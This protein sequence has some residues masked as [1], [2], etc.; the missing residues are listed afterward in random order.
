MNKLITSAIVLLLSLTA[1]A[2]VPVATYEMKTDNFKQ[3]DETTMSFELWFRKTSGED[4]GLFTWQL[5]WQFNT[6]ALNGGAFQ[7]ANFTIAPGADGGIFMGHYNNADAVVAPNGTFFSY[8]P[9]SFPNVGENMTVITADWKHIA[10]F[11]AQATKNGNPHNFAAAHLELA[12][13]IGGIVEVFASQNPYIFRTEGQITGTLTT[14]P[15]APISDREM[16]SHWFTG[17]GNWTDAA[18]WNNVTTENANTVPGA[19][20]N[21]GIGGSATI[22]DAKTAGEVTVAQGG[23]LLVNEAG[24]LTADLVFN[25]NS[26]APATDVTV[27]LWD[28]EAGEGGNLPYTA[29]Q[30]NTVNDGI[31]SFTTTANVT[32]ILDAGDL[33]ITGGTLGPFADVWRGGLPAT[34][35]AWVAQFSSVGIENLKLSSVQW[36]DLNDDLGS[37]VGPNSFS[38]QY[39]F[40]NSSWTTITTITVSNDLTTGVLADQALPSALDNQAVVY[41]RWRT[42]ATDNT[43]NGFSFIDNVVIVGDEMPAGITLQSSASGT[44][45]LIH[46]NTGVAATVQR[47]LPGAAAAWHGISAPVSGMDILASEWYPGA[48]EDLYLWS[49]AAPGWWVNVKN[50][51]GSGGTPDFPTANGGNDFAMGRGYIVNYNSA[52][53]TKSFAG[54]LNAGELQVPLLYNSSKLWE[55]E[56]GWNL[57]GNPY[58]SGLNFNTINK[59]NLAEDYAQ[60]YDPNKDGG[61]GYVTATT[62]AAGQAFFV[63]AANS[64]AFLGLQ[65]T[66]QLHGGTFY[67]NQTAANDKLLL[68]LSNDTYYDETQLLLKAGSQAGYDYYDASKIYSLNNEIPQ[69]SS[70]VDQRPLLINSI[71]QLSPSTIV[72]LRLLIPANG[73]Y[74]LEA[75]TIEGAFEQE[76]LFV[77][78]LETGLIHDLKESAYTFTAKGGDTDRLQIQFEVVGLSETENVNAK[79]WYANNHIHINGVTGTYTVQLT[80]LSGRFLFSREAELKLTDQFAVL[81]E[82]GVY[83]LVLNG[84]KQTQTLKV[85]VD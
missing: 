11:T 41:L 46:N 14:A 57:V 21:V 15:G 23:L 32:G 84:E 80:D 83:L 72:P 42:N 4:F 38:L 30:G 8:T 48:D 59:S 81:L 33:G 3:L 49:E 39:S 1:I 64:A 78:D 13:R 35:K 63:K 29:D 2:Q 24:E 50:Q 20:A 66:D 53:P 47:Y 71:P 43:K 62:I 31:A 19:S 58:A 76:G 73:E 22:T 27:A 82:P 70:R 79:A 60:V 77:S 7:T 37:G 44:G 68:R 12:H 40:D 52:N 55:W 45:S 36:S 56:A 51:D 75:Q 26:G 28:F 16:A 61:E 69:L 25:E 10:T 6:A 18:R 34:Q 54:Q 85:Q 17:A 9:S 74:T 65:T 67:K 5:Q